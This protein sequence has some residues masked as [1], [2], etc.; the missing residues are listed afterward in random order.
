MRVMKRITNTGPGEWSVRLETAHGTF[1]AKYKN[2]KMVNGS[3]EPPTEQ[4]TESWDESQRLLRRAG[5]CDQ[6]SEV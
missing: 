4:L 1:T 2:G 6:P 3:H 5:C